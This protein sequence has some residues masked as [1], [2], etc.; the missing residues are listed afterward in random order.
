MRLLLL[1]LV[2]HSGRRKNVFVPQDETAMQIEKT[3]YAC[4]AA[5]LMDF[6]LAQNAR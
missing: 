2:G 6:L 3:Q 5:V 4:W 1:L